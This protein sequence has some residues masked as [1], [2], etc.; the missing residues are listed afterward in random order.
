MKIPKLPDNIRVHPNVWATIKEIQILDDEK[1]GK[2]I[3]RIA[4]LGTDPMPM[5]EDCK[6]ETVWNLSKKKI[7]VKRL[8]C[9]DVLDYRIFYAYKKSGLVCVYCIVE[10]NND[11]YRKDSWHYQIIKLL[12]TQWRE[13]Q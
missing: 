5:T 10:K 8:K 12:Y 4:A 1:A 7:Y 3:Q 11:T 6:S 9:I 13:C 2:I